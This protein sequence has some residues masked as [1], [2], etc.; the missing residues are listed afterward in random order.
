M[1]SEAD[2]VAMTRRNLQ[3]EAKQHGI[4][5]NLSSREIVR[6][7]LALRAA[8]D[9]AVDESAASSGT[10]PDA[11][12]KTPD[13]AIDHES[14]EPTCEKGRLSDAAVLAE[15]LG[16]LSQRLDR[17]R[18]S[19]LSAPPDS[20]GS[21]AISNDTVNTAGLME[22]PVV[23]K[24]TKE[25]HDSLD[26]QISLDILPPKTLDMLPITQS[27]SKNRPSSIGAALRTTFGSVST[28]EPA[29]AASQT[30]STQAVNTEVQASGLSS[31]KKIFESEEYWRLR[32]EHSERKRRRLE[33]GG[34]SDTADIDVTA[35]ES[36]QS[37]CKRMAGLVREV[38]QVVTPHK[39]P[40]TAMFDSTT[41]GA[42]HANS[43]ASNPWTPTAARWEIGAGRACKPFE[44]SFEETCPEKASPS[45][46]PR[47]DS[48][49]FRRD[50]AELPST[51][52]AGD[53]VCTTTTPR[54]SIKGLRKS[55]GAGSGLRGRK[56]MR[57][58][59]VAC[60]D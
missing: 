59:N 38:T 49:V 58:S 16:S 35:G 34:D 46:R 3:A 60:K 32:A 33:Q 40:P 10:N 28:S 29:P 30:T 31:T 36:T 15:R 44:A 1:A 43:T 39:R 21:E 4:K 57:L 24:E 14:T 22:G 51:P 17:A 23:Q 26:A 37:F 54:S 25:S 55:L 53:S 47:A 48:E 19:L 56:P 2:L 42:P 52:V 6:Q 18:L 45:P 50:T 8:P 20:V 41:F 5:A 7:L 12:H 11:E 9:H 27:A 13:T